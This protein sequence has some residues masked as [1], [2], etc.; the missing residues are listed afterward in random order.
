MA[1]TDKRSNS[2]R[3]CYM[4]TKMP[5]STLWR[6]SLRTDTLL[7]I[8]EWW[9]DRPW[10]Y[11]KSS[12]T[13]LRKSLRSITSKRHTLIGAK[14]NQRSV[15]KQTSEHTRILLY[16]ALELSMHWI[17]LAYQ[18]KILREICETLKALQYLL[19]PYCQTKSSRTYQIKQRSVASLK[20]LL[21]A[22]QRPP[23]ILLKLT[24]L[25]E[26]G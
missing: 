1:T 15:Q 25:A 22:N 26:V 10:L 23:V 20:S 4:S 8:L 17:I 19:Q 5:K 11:Q 9:I 6:Y 21:H 18:K 24:L 14:K 12:Q 3:H 16:Y 2:L 13:S 7:K